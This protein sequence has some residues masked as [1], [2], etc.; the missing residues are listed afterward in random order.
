MYAMLQMAPAGGF[1]ASPEEESSQPSSPSHG[2]ANEPAAPAAEEGVVAL[3]AEAGPVVPY[4]EPTRSKDQVLKAVL[5]EIEHGDTW[6]R[7]AALLSIHQVVPKG[8][9]DA[10]GAI[11]ARLKHEDPSVREAAL[12]TLFKLMPAVRSKEMIDDVSSLLQDPDWKVRQV[13]IES[14]VR[15]AGMDRAIESVCWR[16]EHKDPGV[17]DSALTALTRVAKKGDPRIVALVCWRL[18]HPKDYVREASL[19]GIPRVACWGDQNAIAEITLRFEHAQSPVRE[20]A[21]RGIVLVARRGDKCGIAQSVARLENPLAGCRE[22][23]L[24]ALTE[25]AVTGDKPTIDAVAQRLEDTDLVVRETAIINLTKTQ[26][27]QN[28]ACLRICNRL[29]NLRAEVRASALKAWKLVAWRGHV[30]AILQ[31][32]LRLNKTLVS[33]DQGVVDTALA[34]LVFV[35]PAE[36]NQAVCLVRAQ[37]DHYSLEIRKMAL[38]AIGVPL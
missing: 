8:D 17:R 3:R 6:S 13:A 25:L 28:H 7:K 22:I 32:C 19:A 10:V 11:H 24:R 30:E 2:P 18:E 16:M 20:A 21:L 38:D 27:G 29:E 14:F 33:P 37:V 1:V 35:A 12:K 5:S 4:V 31:V 15:L 23:A 26:A 34:A 9:P 36:D